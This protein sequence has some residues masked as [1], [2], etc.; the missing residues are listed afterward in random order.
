VVN[1]NTNFYVRYYA[2]GDEDYTNATYHYGDIGYIQ[3]ELTA[4][5]IPDA[6][7]L[8]CSGLLGLIGF[9]KRIHR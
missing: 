3:L 5:P 6:I 4:V 7:W 2:T 8:L 1:E 9:R